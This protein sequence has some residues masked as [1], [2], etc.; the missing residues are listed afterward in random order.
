VEHI[1]ALRSLLLNLFPDS[2]ALR[3]QLRSH[4]KLRLLDDGLPGAIAGRAQVV[5][6]VVELLHARGLGLDFIDALLAEDLYEGRR[7]E[8]KQVRALWERGAAQ[9]SAPSSSASSTVRQQIINNG[10][11]G[12]QFNVAG[13]ATFNFG[14][15]GSMPGTRTIASPGQ[16][17]ALPVVV[18]L[19]ALEVEYNAVHGHLTDPKEDEHPAGSLYE[20]ALYPAKAP[21]CR[22]AIVEIGAG[23][24]GA[25]VAV[26]RAITHFSPRFVLFVG[27]AGGLKDVAIGDVVCSTK[28]YGYEGGKEADD[29]F[30]PRPVAFNT[31]ARLLA[32][33]LSVKRSHNR[34]G[35]TFRVFDGPIAAGEKLVADS[36]SATAKLLRQN[37]GDALAVE[38]EGVGF[39]EGAHQSHVEGL[40]VRGISDTLDGKSEADA[41]GSQARAS[42]HAASVV[43]RII[44]GLA[45]SLG[46]VQHPQ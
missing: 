17:S 19:T 32:R 25:A 43:F 6:A 27:V 39:L 5:D 9:P 35:G 37:Y 10:S 20:V 28:V 29:G 23:N 13:D 21:F 24:R 12:R 38:M 30:R 8:L 45:S 4:A 1:E 31:S 18:I 26:E 16:A 15:G 7:A 42:E 36:K 14:Q 3:R 22:I 41:G 40:I 46:P 11:V 2:G 44:E 33:A 34:E